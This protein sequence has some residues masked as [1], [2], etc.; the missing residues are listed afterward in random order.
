LL[1]QGQRHSSSSHLLAEKE[2]ASRA[3][4]LS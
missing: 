1:S 2:P 4:L 3:S